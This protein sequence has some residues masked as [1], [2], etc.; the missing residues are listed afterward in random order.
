[1]PSFPQNKSKKETSAVKVSSFSGWISSFSVAG[2][3]PPL[4]LEVT[5]NE[6]AGKSCPRIAFARFH[7][8]DAPMLFLLT[9]SCMKIPFLDLVRTIRAEKMSL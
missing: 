5:A 3:E 4:R 1:M 2:S 7:S 6:K 8:S 9:K